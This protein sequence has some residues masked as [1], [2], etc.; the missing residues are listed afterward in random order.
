MS[1]GHLIRQNACNS[2]VQE[3]VVALL[4][5]GTLYNATPMLPI[6]VSALEAY[7]LYI[8]QSLSSAESVGLVK[9]RI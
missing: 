7:A 1:A 3:C 8:W 5:P 4:K 9:S 6:M 2:T